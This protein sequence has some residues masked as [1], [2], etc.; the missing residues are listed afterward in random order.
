MDESWAGKNRTRNYL[1][2]CPFETWKLGFEKLNYG[3]ALNRKNHTG[4]QIRVRLCNSNLNRAGISIPHTT[5][6]LQYG[7]GRDWYTIRAAVGIPVPN[8]DCVINRYNILYCHDDSSQ[9]PQ[10]QFHSKCSG[11]LLSL[12]IDLTRMCIHILLS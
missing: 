10:L 8:R 3:Q 6:A 4:F 1:V 9:E 2:M 12:A 11:T 5:G 7:I